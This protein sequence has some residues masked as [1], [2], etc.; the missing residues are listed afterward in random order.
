LTLPEEYFGA[1]AGKVWKSMADGE[2]LSVK[3]ISKR[4]SLKE[5]EVLGALGWLAREGKVE[6]KGAV[7]LLKFKLK[8]GECLL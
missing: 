6:I 2:T 8:E 4:S 1:N 7:P 3:E 5:M